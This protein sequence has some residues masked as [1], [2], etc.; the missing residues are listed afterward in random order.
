[1]VGFGPKQAWFAVRAVQGVDRALVMAALDLRDLGE[2][3]WRSGIDLA[4]LTDDRLVLTPP[5]PGVDGTPWILATGRWLLGA[6]GATGVAARVR[7]APLSATLGT[8]VQFFLTYRV[9]EWH[10][11]ERAID[12][13]AVRVF[14][15]VGADGEVTEWWGEPDAVELA[16]GLPP[17]LD[18]DRDVLVSE[19]GVLSVAGGWS[20]DPTALA[21][22]PSAGPVRVGAVP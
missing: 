13:T 3:P 7:T 14:E 6:A 2:V 12:G 22:R 1:M 19:R 8:E 16:A 9:T 4:H 20:V 21:G 17:A 5:V 11:W 18:G 10:R 15:F